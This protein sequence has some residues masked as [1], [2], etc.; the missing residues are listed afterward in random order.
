MELQLELEEA[1]KQVEEAHKQA[2]EAHKQAEE[3]RKEKE[4]ANKKVSQM[5]QEMT[6]IIQTMLSNGMSVSEI[7]KCVSKSEEEIMK[8]ISQPPLWWLFYFRFKW[9][10]KI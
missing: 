1:H 7:A 3:A 2:E 4:E 9:K 6:L 10:K 8:W 5:S